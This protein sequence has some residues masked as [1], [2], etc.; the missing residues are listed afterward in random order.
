MR[1]VSLG[2]ALIVASTIQIV[3]SQGYDKQALA[4]W[5][6]GIQPERVV[7]AVNCGSNEKLTDLAGITYEPVRFCTFERP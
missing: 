3:S 6:L 2:L 4:G 5:F 7:Y 1:R